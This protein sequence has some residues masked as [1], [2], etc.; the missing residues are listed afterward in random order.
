MSL[1]YSYDLV[2]RLLDNESLR[3]NTNKF[4]HILGF[5]FCFC[6]WKY[7]KRMLLKVNFELL[8][9]ISL[10][11]AELR[12]ARRLIGI[13]ERI[14][15]NKQQLHFL[16]QCRA[17]QIYPPTV[18][19]LHL[20]A[21][22]KHSFLTNKASSI[23]DAVMNGIQRHIQTQIAF[24]IN[25]RKNLEDSIRQLTSSETSYTII[26]IGYLAF[27]NASSLSQQRLTKRLSFIIQKQQ[28]RRHSSTNHSNQHPISFSTSND[29]DLNNMKKKLVTDLTES[30]ND[31]ELQLLSKGPKFKMTTPLNQ[32]TIMEVRTSFCRLAYQMRWRS[33][34]PENINNNIPMYP[35]SDYIIEPPPADRELDRKL[36]NAY[37]KI[38]RLLNIE[39]SK[40][41]QPNLSIEERTTLRQLKAK[42]LVFLP[43]DKG[44]EFCVLQKELYTELGNQHLS[45][46]TIYKAINH[47]QAKTVE[48]KLN[49]VWSNICHRREIQKRIEISFRSSNTEL[50]T[51]YH[52]IKTHKS[53]PQTKIRPIVSN[54]NGP[55]KKLAWLLSKL[56]SPL[57]KNVPAHLENS[58][59]LINRIEM[60]EKTT[61]EEFNYPFSLD[62]VSLYTSIPPAEAIKNVEN[63][64]VATNTRHDPLQTEDITDLL[65]VITKNTYFQF[66]GHIFLQI[67]GLAMGSS[68]SAILAILFMDTLEKRALTNTISHRCYNRYVDDIFTLSKDKQSATEL[69][70]IMN[71][72]HNNIKFEIE[73]P[74]ENNSLR[75]LDFQV[76]IE[77]D[78][79]SHYDFYKKTAKA[80]IFM[81]AD[82]AIP[83]NAKKCII[84]NEVERIKL[85]CTNNEDAQRNL[86]TFSKVLR[87]N[88][89][90]NNTIDRLTNRNNKRRNGK[91]NHEN[92]FFFH[93]P[94]INDRIH[95]KVRQ[96][97][98]KEG[99]EVIPYS[100][101]PSLRQL[102][103][104]QQ[105]QKACKLPNCPLSDPLLC[106]RKGVIYEVRCNGCQKRY[107]GSTKRELHTRIKEHITQPTSAIRQH[108][109]ECNTINNI[110]TRILARDNDPKNLRIKEAI[111][112]MDMTPELNRREEETQLSSLVKA[113]TKHQ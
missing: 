2:T 12:S 53:G 54:V 95:T 48:K 44:G 34:I 81:N 38:T 61:K 43:S 42:P 22:F 10:S 18:Q 90:P 104:T 87:A 15:R 74:D 7:Y 84:R 24:G 50:P 102:L 26:R 28:H 27:G 70:T 55:T 5:L 83:Q 9:H 99:L 72:V 85:R 80:P 16:R 51:F 3:E 62:V 71:S 66:N 36:M 93:L 58:L 6:L 96:I 69:H 23:K 14:A 57:L 101:N 67:D 25:E 4:N 97:F 40:K 109:N 56:L 65:E 13:C 19:N 82:T 21:C 86:D 106:N 103:K 11:Q 30:L 68:V 113:V 33:R 41:I 75:L 112:I 17:H 94:F 59:E 46:R 63:L 77:K 108:L 35:A 32:Q 98:K 73:H 31:E 78:G 111:L 37:H 88:G 76:T 1:H 49:T 47:I 107:I 105:Q 29:A 45:D 79:T 110:S 39:Q 52:L 100:R 64:L 92:N 60:I 20:P 91:I 8:R 89:H